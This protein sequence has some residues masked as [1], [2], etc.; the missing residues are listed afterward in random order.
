MLRVSHIRR[1]VVVALAVGLAAATA[2]AARKPHSA[3]DEVER[4]GH[5]P[6]VEIVVLRF[7]HIPAES[8]AETLDQLG[9]HPAIREGLDQMP[10]AVNEPANA[11]VLIAPPEV[12]DAMRRLA[13]EL[14]QP[15]EFLVH[16]RER[17]AEEA[18][19]IAEM[20]ERERHL[21][22]EQEQF[23]L[24]MDRRRLHLE[25]EEAGTR[26]RLEHAKRQ[27]AGPPGPPPPPRMGD[28]PCGPRCDPDC[29]CPNRGTPRC[30]DAGRPGGPPCRCPR[31]GPKTGPRS[32]GPMWG[33]GRPCPPCPMPGKPCP[34]MGPPP[35]RPCPPPPPR[36]E[37]AER[38]RREMEDA[39]RHRHE[40]EDA[41]RHRHEHL[42]RIEEE[43]RK[44]KEMFDRH[45]QEAEKHLEELERKR[46]HLKEEHRRRMEEFGD[47]LNPE[48]REAHER[49]LHEHVEDLE[50]AREKVRRK[51]EEAHR[52]LEEH[53]RNLERK[54]HELM[55]EPWG[56]KPRPE[57][58]RRP[59][60]ER[61]RPEGEARGLGP[62]PMGPGLG[63]L[64]TPDGREALGLSDE[65][66]EQIESLVGRLRRHMEETF[67]GIRDK[68]HRTDPEDRE[69]LLGEIREK[70]AGRWGE[71]RR[72]VMDRLAEILNPDQRERMKDWMQ[73]RG[74]GRGPGRRGFGPPGPP[75]RP[76]P[77]RGRGPHRPSGLQR[78]A[79]CRML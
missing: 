4:E 66:A 1:I 74:P 43:Q 38:R 12:A 79:G 29:R 10:T 72:N 45:H 27:L 2:S 40:M 7:V 34:K 77:G 41:E 26:L 57:E 25:R 70:M 56:D 75:P 63:R 51:V 64:L 14:D 61:P 78:P 50:R 33:P 58:P 44:V 5:E 55:E 32:R 47:R 3:L 59:D 13:D 21:D 52:Q 23:D 39:E 73:E 15:N 36:H 68:L 46:H 16:E 30:R 60:K 17:E 24:E 62:G 20:E 42:E 35:G 54:K 19:F 48:Q 76:Q 37:K 31:C 65:Q 22:H 18:A 49:A 6:E 53:L 28:R 8:F 9:E 69:H 71:L 67:E 11:V